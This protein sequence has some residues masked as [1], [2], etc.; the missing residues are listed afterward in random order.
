MVGFTSAVDAYGLFDGGGVVRDGQVVKLHVRE[1]LQQR[2][3]DEN[4]TGARVAN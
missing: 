2:H 4:R 3:K 1:G